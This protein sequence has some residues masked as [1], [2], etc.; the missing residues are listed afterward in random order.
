MGRQGKVG[1]GFARPGGLAGPSW[2]GRMGFGQGDRLLNRK[3][4][5]DTVGTVMTPRPLLIL[6][7]VVGS[8][9][10]CR[11]GCYAEKGR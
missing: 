11:S 5:E 2:R 7:T 9:V 10:K 6:L 4:T 3:I 8:G 1:I